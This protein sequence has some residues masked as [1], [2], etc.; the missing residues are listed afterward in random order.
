MRPNCPGSWLTLKGQDWPDNL[1]QVSSPTGSDF[2]QLDPRDVPRGERV[3]WLVERLRTSIADG[4]LGLGTRLPATRVLADELGF[5]RG[6]VEE[7]F[8]RL[9]EE[10]LLRANRGA[11]TSIAT[12][13]AAPAAR[14]A[15]TATDSTDESLI[16]L[17]AGVPDLSSFPRAAW[18][19]TERQVL[20]TATDRQL[21]YAPPQGLTEL[22]TELATWLARSRGVLTTPD[23]IVI[24]G[25]V[26]GSLSAL[27]QVLQNRGHSTVAIEDPGAEGN[28]R[29]LQRWASSVLPIAVD[30]QGIDAGELQ[31]SSADLAVITPAHQYPTGVVL[32]SERRRRVV[33]WAR[34]AGGMIIEDDYD[35]EYRYDRSPVRAMQPLAPEVISYTASLSKILA[36]A[37][38]LGWV[39]VPPRLVDEIVEVRW[40]TDLGTPALPQLVLAE[41]LRNGTLARQLRSMRARH[42]NRRDVAVAAVRTEL[43]GCAV[44][45]IA[46]GIHLFIDLPASTDDVAIAARARHAGVLIRPLS[47]HRMT[48][49][50]PGLVLAYA[51]HSLAVL[52]S[53]IARI[54][55]VLT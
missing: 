16:D 49:G 31:Q 24:T 36:P 15:P 39:V 25:G 4:T 54:G 19:R 11:G 47:D 2:L 55:S 38:R 20:D 13:P 30:D 46:A 44:R 10:G 42:R 5:A 29:I 12:R 51:N 6:T 27:Y 34:T 21:G 22:R 52:R 18:L 53:A 23:Q 50:P 28:R 37:L 33:E 35:A 9:S 3:S 45:G 7:A 41:L 43:P 32:S 1:G 48:P 26:T 14:T 8:R 17:S 40:A